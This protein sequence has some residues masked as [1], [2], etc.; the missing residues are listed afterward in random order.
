MCPRRIAIRA[1]G[2][3]RSGTCRGSCA[4]C[5]PSA[6]SRKSWGHSPSGPAAGPAPGQRP[7][8]RARRGLPPP[9]RGARRSQQATG[10]RL[11]GTSPFRRAAVR[12][13][14]LSATM[15]AGTLAHRASG[16]AQQPAFIAPKPRQPPPRAAPAGR[17]VPTRPRWS[18]A[19]AAPACRCLSASPPHRAGR[20][21]GQNPGSPP[22]SAA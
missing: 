21:P 6:H 9:G 17:A 7:W 11:P 10:P 18:A 15:P 13:A 4:A 22:L 1:V 16:C 12:Q 5:R 19:R 20:C 14:P 8:R 3:S 2:R